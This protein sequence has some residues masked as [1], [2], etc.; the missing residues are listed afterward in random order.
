MRSREREK[1][2]GKHVTKRDRRIVEAVFYAR[3]MTRK[4]IARLFFP[5]EICSN[6]GNRMVILYRK[7]L[8]DRRVLLRDQ[9]VV[10]Y[11]GLQGR[12]Y[13][14]ETLG[15]DQKYVDD[16]AGVDGK[17]MTVHDLG[18]TDV[19]VSLARQCEK[20]NWTLEYQNA[21]MLELKKW[22]VQPDGVFRIAEVKREAFIEYTDA[23]PTAMEMRGKLKGYAQLFGDAPT[24]ILWFTNSRTNIHWLVKHV[25]GWAYEDYCLVGLLEEDFLTEA[26]WKWVNGEELVR[27]IPRKEVE[28][29]LNPPCQPMP[30]DATRGERE[31]VIPTAR[32]HPSPSESPSGALPAVTRKP[33]PLL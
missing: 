33:G 27:F 9:P 13:I 19:Y 26:V 5:S 14:A 22:P 7:G 11:L 3:Y 32:E 12:R 10:N 28:G 18:V 8:L 30:A 15:L 21:R 2:K 17:T 25:R 6:C 20:H 31:C 16:I 23:L 4:Q 29:R 1:A 24:P